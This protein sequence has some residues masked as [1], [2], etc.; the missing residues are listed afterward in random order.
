[1]RLQKYMLKD[2][3][4]DW[5]SSQLDAVLNRPV[6]F[7]VGE[8]VSHG[9]YIVSVRTFI[10]L[11][12]RYHIYFDKRIVDEKSLNPDFKY[13]VTKYN[14]SINY[15]LDGYLAEDNYLTVWSDQ[16]A[17]IAKFDTR[18]ECKEYI[19]NLWDYILKHFKE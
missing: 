4:S 2:V 3:E 16:G 11:E 7:M 19:N 8:R 10:D 18:E 13:F 17:V 9:Y 6:I 12:E 14:K 1:M 15:E 5:K